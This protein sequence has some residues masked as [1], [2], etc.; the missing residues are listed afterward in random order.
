MMN[1]T[2]LRKVLKTCTLVLDQDSNKM[3]EAVVTVK[4]T[5]ESFVEY[6]NNLTSLLGNIEKQLKK[7]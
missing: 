3:L 5:H 1:H 7:L 4:K 2:K 6:G